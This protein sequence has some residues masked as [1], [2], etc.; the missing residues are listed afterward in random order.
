MGDNMIILG[1][2]IG[3]TNVRSG[4]VD[5]HN[6]LS[7]FR[8]GKTAEVFT[9]GT[10]EDLCTYIDSLL[11]GQDR[12][13]A[14]SIGIPST[15]DKNNRRIFSTPNIKGFDNIDVAS[16]VENRFNIPA[17]VS[18]D[19]CLSLLYDINSNRL[20]KEGF[21]VGF[22][23]GTG[24]GNAI[25]FN[26]EIVVG[27]NGVAGEL[28]HIPVLGRTDTC[29]CGNKGCIELYASGRY[30]T[31]INKEYF[32]G[33]DITDIFIKHGNF[34]LIESF[35]DNVAAAIATEINILDPEIII[36]GGGVIM[37]PGFPREKLEAAII[38]Y[39]RKPYP[40]ENLNFIYAKESNES[41]VIGAGIFAFQKIKAI[42]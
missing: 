10:S 3:G 27:R 38:K 15:V 32:P 7:D 34:P 19:V 40:A 41:G 5:Q 24:T 35:V 9:S 29:I 6:R 31:Q 13:N 28:G 1:M 4:F 30:L 23:I 16:L 36:L 25:S 12:P 42:L 26:G 33:E 21:I 8:I 2:D 18:R 39:A 37:L 11:Q 14:I 17:F 20:K 22:Y